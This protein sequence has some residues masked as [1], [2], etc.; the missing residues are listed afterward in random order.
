MHCYMHDCYMHDC[1]INHIT[2]YRTIPCTH[3]V[4]YLYRALIFPF[5]VSFS[6]AAQVNYEIDYQRMNSST[7]SISNLQNNKECIL[8]PNEND[9]DSIMITQSPLQ[10]KILDVEVTPV[11]AHIRIYGSL[12]IC[13]YVYI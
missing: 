9:N 2:F 5:N 4:I 3:L 13:V 8:N 7:S 12:Y 6:M 11:S 1:Y 10:A